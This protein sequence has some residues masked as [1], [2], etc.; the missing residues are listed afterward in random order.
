M[1]ICTYVHTSQ[2]FVRQD[3]YQDKFV[4]F[5]FFARLNTYLREAIMNCNLIITKF[6]DSFLNIICN[7][8]ASENVKIFKQSQRLHHYNFWS[9]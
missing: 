5:I 7:N 8:A 2:I 1:S 3:N 4:I 9:F 6:S